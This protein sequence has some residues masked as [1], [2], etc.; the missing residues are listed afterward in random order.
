MGGL[1]ESKSSFGHNSTLSDVGKLNYHRS[2]LEGLVLAA[3]TGPGLKLLVVNILC[4]SHWNAASKVWQWTTNHVLVAT[5]HTARLWHH[6]P[7]LK[8]LARCLHDQV[9]RI[10]EVQ[11]NL[12]GNLLVMVNQSTHLLPRSFVNIT[13]NSN[14]HG[15]GK[16]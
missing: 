6:L 4:W 10:F 13:H 12:Y 15:T 16:N 7:T 8:S 9:S 2:L 3:A 11:L 5:A 1:L 14:R